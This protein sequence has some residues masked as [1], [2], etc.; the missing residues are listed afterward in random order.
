MNYLYGMVDRRKAISLISSRD[1]FKRSSPFSEIFTTANL[2][3]AASRI[4]ISAEPEFRLSDNHCTTV[5]HKSLT[6][7]VNLTFKVSL[8]CILLLYSLFSCTPFLP[9]MY[10]SCF[11]TYNTQHITSQRFSVFS[12]CIFLKSY[13]YNYI[14]CY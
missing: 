5:I 4:W 3:Y 13:F 1:H 9:L 8:I 11:I 6:L 7:K 14:Y 2:R 12:F 10:A